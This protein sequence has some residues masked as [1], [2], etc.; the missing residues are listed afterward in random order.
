[1]TVGILLG[2]I[3]GV[4]SY[5]SEYAA[6]LDSRHNHIPLPLFRSQ[7]QINCTSVDCTTENTRVLVAVAQRETDKL[8]LWNWWKSASAG[9][10]EKVKEQSYLIRVR[11]N[12][13][14][15]SIKTLPLWVKKAPRPSTECPNQKTPNEVLHN[16]SV[17][18]RAPAV[19]LGLSSSFSL[20][21]GDP[22][23]VSE[24]PTQRDSEV[25][26]I[27]ICKVCT[28]ATSVTCSRH[29]PQ[30][31]SSAHSI[32][33]PDPQMAT[34]SAPQLQKTLQMTSDAS[35]IRGSTVPSSDISSDHS[36]SLALGGSL[37]LSVTPSMMRFSQSSKAPTEVSAAADSSEQ[38]SGDNFSN[39]S[40]PQPRPRSAPPEIE[41]TVRWATWSSHI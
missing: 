20:S 19:S 39:S 10:L 24:H 30:Y 31:P 36:T 34:H 4:I 27:T 13:R 14:L 29:Y 18:S 12:R 22:F 2:T 1:M 6:V 15:P 9:E 37:S 3:C 33:A 5:R 7:T 23:A 16:C 17:L 25:P 41:P 21:L 32:I 11:N 40:I 38:A 28:R 35:S 8:M 26:A